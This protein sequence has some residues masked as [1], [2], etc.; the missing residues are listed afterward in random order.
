MSKI[1]GFPPGVH[2]LAGQFEDNVRAFN[3]GDRRSGERA[4]RLL[5]DLIDR[6]VEFRGEFGRMLEDEAT[7]RAG[8]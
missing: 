1:T 3:N 2:T 5:G 4:W 8:T 7:R 6:L